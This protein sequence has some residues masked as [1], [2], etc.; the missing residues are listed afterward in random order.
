MLELGDEPR[1]AVL[2]DRHHMAG[3]AELHFERLAEEPWMDA[4]T[5]RHWCDFWRVTERRSD[6]LPVS[7]VC[8]S[9]ESCWSPH[10]RGAPLASCPPRSPRPVRGRACDTC[11]SSTSPR[12]STR[13]PG[14]S[15]IADRSSPMLSKPPARCAAQMSVSPLKAPHPST[16]RPICT[17]DRS[18]PRA[19]GD[20]RRPRLAWRSAP[21]SQNPETTSTWPSLPPSTHV[22]SPLSSP[23]ASCPST[24]RGGPVA[25]AE[26]RTP[27]RAH[28]PGQDGLDG[29]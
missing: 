5:D 28:H 3:E 17:A 29:P 22:P 16:T 1:Y 8:S 9:Y 21:L 11:Q 27:A 6:P 18:S 23:K 19:V 24:G 20:S 26:K 15:A 14:G 12:R 13:W 7:A 4:E 25:R 10:A 2:G